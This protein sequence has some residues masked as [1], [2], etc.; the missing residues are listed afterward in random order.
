MCCAWAIGLFRLDLNPVM[1]LLGRGG[2][3][4]CGIVMVGQHGIA[5]NRLIL[6][7]KNFSPERWRK[8]IA[9]GYPVIPSRHE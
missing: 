4:Y 8:Q 5:G 7:E 1:V 6:M 9:C 3:C 2:A